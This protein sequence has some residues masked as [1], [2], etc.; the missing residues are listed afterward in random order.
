MNV[1]DCT[2]YFPFKCNFLFFSDSPCIS[3]KTRLSFAG[4][5]PMKNASQLVLSSSLLLLLHVVF[6][7]TGVHVVVGVLAVAGVPA[8]LHD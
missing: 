2:R 6:S 1:A 8:V 7:G 5:P 4:V 3:T